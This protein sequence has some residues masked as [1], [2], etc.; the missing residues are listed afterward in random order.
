[1]SNL[2]YIVAVFLVV[3]W[4]LGYFGLQIAG[5]LL[6]VLLFLSILSVLLGVIKSGR[7]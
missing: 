2:L 7:L 4:L 3:A 1:M 6:H 5:G